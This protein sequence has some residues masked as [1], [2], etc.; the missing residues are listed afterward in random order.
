MLPDSLD[1]YEIKEHQKF[2]NESSYLST[3]LVWFGVFIP[4]HAP[5]WFGVYIP[6]YWFG[7]VVPRNT[8]EDRDPET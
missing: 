4:K 5:V 2:H 8:R 3:G 7:L 6:K 1:Y